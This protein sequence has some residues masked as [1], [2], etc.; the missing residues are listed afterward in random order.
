MIHHLPD[1]TV[2]EI[3]TVTHLESVFLDDVPVERG[4]WLARRQ[5]DAVHPPQAGRGLGR[6]QRALLHVEDPTVF[7]IE[8]R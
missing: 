6:L 4:R 3:A 5:R 7:L 1:V 2:I 8:T